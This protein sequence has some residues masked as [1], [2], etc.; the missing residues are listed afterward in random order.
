MLNKSLIQAIFFG[1]LL[2]LV[3][4]SGA[5]ETATKADADQKVYR[6]FHTDGVVEFT[7]QPSKGSEELQVETLPTYPFAPAVST[8]KATPRLKQI[9]LKPGENVPYSSLNINYPNHDESIRANNG[10]LEAKFT[11]TPS[12][13]A[14]QGHQYEYLLDGKSV[15][16]SN[17]PQTL[18]NI[19]RGSHT[20]VIQVID[21]NNKVLIHSGSVTFHLKRFFKSTP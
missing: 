4:A 21:Q 11:L 1:S 13:Q 14:H 6:K 9:K 17:K 3:T 19:D 7:D 10:E 20:L 2:S 12:L 15:L 5:E 16:K 8:P 18:K